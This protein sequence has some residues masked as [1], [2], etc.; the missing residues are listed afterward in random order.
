MIQ[1]QYRCFLISLSYLNVVADILVLQSFL[2]RFFA[3]RLTKKMK[4]HEVFKRHINS[5]KIHSQWRMMFCYVN[6]VNDLADILQLQSFFRR[7]I[8]VKKFKKL[9]LEEMENQLENRKVCATAIQSQWRSLSS[10]LSNLNVLSDIL[11]I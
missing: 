1:S 11:E 2:R 5:I 7:R 10:S 3:S 8:A 9:K 6:Y 4:Q